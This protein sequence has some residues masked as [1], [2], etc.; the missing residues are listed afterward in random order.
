MK[1]VITG[2]LGHIGSRLIREL[3]SFDSDLDIVMVDDLS[4][5]RYAALFDLP[6]S[7]RYQFV[8]ADVTDG[9]VEDLVKGATAVVHLAAI[10][11]ATSSF[12]KREV[13]ERV[14]LTATARVAE[15]CR[16]TDVPM[17]MLS[18]TSVYGSQN[19]VVDEYC[20]RTDLNPQSPYAETKL[21]EE[22]LVRE[23]TSSKGLKAVICRFGTI[24]GTSSGMRFHTAVNKFCWQAVMGRP[25][26]VWKTAYDQKRPYLDLGDAV[27]AIIFIIKNRLFDGNV[28][29]VVTENATVREVV[30]HI[31]VHVPSLVIEF[32]ETEIM[33]QLSYEVTNT[34]MR[35]VGFKVHGG[36]AGGIRETITLLRNAGKH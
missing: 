29:N 5:Q 22:E 27:S 21:R 33:N 18:T 32:V 20:P 35:D 23:M 12:E 17:V 34:R 31:R 11:D 36:M 26:T 16:S 9:E 10:T 24:Y 25:I 13:V 6:N 3:P 4:T 8:E 1:I 30:E 14:N 7:A 2:A 28:Y 15:A 19:T